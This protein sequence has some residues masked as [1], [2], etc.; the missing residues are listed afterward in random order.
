MSSAATSPTPTSQ[1]PRSIRMT[2]Y[3]GRPIVRSISAVSSMAKFS[4]LTNRSPLR[5]RDSLPDIRPRPPILQIRD[6][7]SRYV[8]D[9]IKTDVY[10]NSPFTRPKR[11]PIIRP[12]N[13]TEDRHSAGYFRS[14]VVQQ[15]MGR[16][17]SADEYR[18]IPPEKRGLHR[19]SARRRSMP[20]PPPIELDE[21]ERGFVLDSV[22]SERRRNKQNPI[23]VEYNAM[24]DIHARR[25]IHRRMVQSLLKRTAFSPQKLYPTIT[26]YAPTKND[27]VV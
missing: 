9:G 4:H 12:Y 26:F 20:T 16:I 24:N 1:P 18:R 17:H 15:V 5:I 13:A 23:Y 27:I 8:L 3:S 2:P 21:R 6:R 11:T 19:L 10:H 22:K 14:P 7:E 25:Y